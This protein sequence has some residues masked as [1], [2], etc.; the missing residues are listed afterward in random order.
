MERAPGGEQADG[1]VV[2]RA[3]TQ[4]GDTADG[5]TA[6]LTVYLPTERPQDVLEQHL[7]HYAAEFRN[8]IVAA[9]SARA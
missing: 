3:L 8:R 7:R 6:S 5:F 1:T 9:A 2:G 4:F